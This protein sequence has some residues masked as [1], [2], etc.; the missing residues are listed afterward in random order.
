MGDERNDSKTGN[1]I[2]K[3]TDLIKQKQASVNNNERH[4]KLPRGAKTGE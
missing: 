2:I 3:N 4:L 1:F